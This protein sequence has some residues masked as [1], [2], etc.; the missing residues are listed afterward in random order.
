ME[1]GREGGEKL[2]TDFPSTCSEMATVPVPLKYLLTLLLNLLA[3]GR[4]HHRHTTYPLHELGVLS[5]ESQG[6][7]IATPL[8]SHALQ[9]TSS[10]LSFCPLTPSPPLHQPPAP[11]LKLASPE[12]QCL[13]CC[14]RCT[15][16]STQSSSALCTSQGGVPGG[17]AGFIPI[18]PI[19]N[20][21][22]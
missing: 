17:V 18:H 12:P 19:G 6:H 16:W 4:P 20:S 13:P 10:I 1:G 21:L 11:P 8:H 14:L 2:K 3:L 7:P 22:K 5:E 9:P 15:Y